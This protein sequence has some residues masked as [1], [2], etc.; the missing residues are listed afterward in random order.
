M[1]R[2]RNHLVTLVIGLAV[3]MSGCSVQ[4]GMQALD[5]AHENVLVAEQ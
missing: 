4:N 1:N 2:Y 3:S 5:R